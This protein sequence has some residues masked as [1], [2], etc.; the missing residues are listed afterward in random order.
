M[1]NINRGH[2]FSAPENTTWI[3]AHCFRCLK[4]G[5][6][7]V[8]GSKS[9]T[10]VLIHSL[11]WDVNL[12]NVDDIWFGS[13]PCDEYAKLGIYARDPL[14]QPT[15]RMRCLKPGFSIA[16]LIHIHT[17]SAILVMDI[18]I[19]YPFWPW[20]YSGPSPL[21]PPVVS[22]PPHSSMHGDGDGEQRVT[23]QLG[24]SLLDK[25]NAMVG[26]VSIPIVL[27][28]KPPVTTIYRQDSWISGATSLK[29]A[30][31]VAHL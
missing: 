28:G 24:T 29:C 27:H 8:F 14:N 22:A 5:R 23:W 13:I 21:V 11:W 20:S 16:I 12:P 25:S 1:V 19:S 9:S 30:L 3:Q 17:A 31:I 26:M 10:P 7:H 2:E 4:K 6:S 18:H 15:T